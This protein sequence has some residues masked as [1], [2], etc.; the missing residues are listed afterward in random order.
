MRGLVML[1]F[2]LV[3]SVHVFSFSKKRDTVNIGAIMN[4]D[5]VNGKVSTIAMKAAVDDVN[6]DP[7]VLP[8]KRLSLSIH[9]ANHSGFLGIAG[10]NVFLVHVILFYP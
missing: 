7:N 8:G 2:V 9:D 1:T 3:F 4:V 6:S 5:T 10:G